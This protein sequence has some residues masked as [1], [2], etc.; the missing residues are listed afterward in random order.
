[1]R[2]CAVHGSVPD[3]GFKY[4]WQTSSIL[5]QGL[6]NELIAITFSYLRS[7]LSKDSFAKN[8]CVAMG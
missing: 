5:A 8:L 6:T 1:M 4:G 2:N 3:M 7:M